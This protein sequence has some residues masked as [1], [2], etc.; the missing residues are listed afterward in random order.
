MSEKEEPQ[1]KTEL[2]D[3]E[4]KNRLAAAE[5]DIQKIADRSMTG[6]HPSLNET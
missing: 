3:E 6:Y 2:S 4:Y 5:L 1:H